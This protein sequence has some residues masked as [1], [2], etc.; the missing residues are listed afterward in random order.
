M[1]WWPRGG[2]TTRSNERGRITDRLPEKPPIVEKPA[3]RRSGRVGRSCPRHPG[4]CI[5]RSISRR[6]GAALPRAASTASSSGERCR[7][8]HRICSLS[9][10]CAT[11]SDCGPGARCRPMFSCSES[12]TRRGGTR[13]RWVALPYWP[14]RSAVAKGSAPAC[15]IGIWRS[16]TLPIHATC[17]RTCRA[18]CWCMLVGEEGD[19]WLAV[20]P[21][22]I[23]LE[24]LPLGLEPIASLEPALMA[25]PGLAFFGAIHRTADYPDAE[26]AAEQSGVRRGSL[27]AIVS[28]TKIGGWPHPIQDYDRDFK[29]TLLCQLGSM[30]PIVRSRIRSGKPS[31]SDRAIIRRAGARRV[32]E[33]T[34]LNGRGHRVHLPQRG[35][36]VQDRRS[37]PID[38]R[39]GPCRSAVGATVR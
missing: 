21:L 13:P 20:E 26:K 9:R 16:S 31:R 35:W 12:A 18:T 2:K 19:D 1:I 32:I 39:R 11:A 8:A 22:A 37:R 7:P 24:W 36:H 33:L 4:S 29:G 23:H 34:Q 3:R 28:G 30:S 27:V 6:S 17:S 38:V 14:V 10:R 5:W 15:L 25:N